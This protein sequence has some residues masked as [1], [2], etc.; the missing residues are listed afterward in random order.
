MNRIRLILEELHFGD[1]Y[2]KV[3]MLLRDSLFLSTMLTNIEAWPSLTI[4]EV[5]EF[6][7]LD[8][9]YLRLVPYFRGAADFTNNQTKMI[10]IFSS[11]YQ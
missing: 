11:H 1:F 8:E 4:R 6:E 5:R 3:A 7:K 10:I 9:E 2:F